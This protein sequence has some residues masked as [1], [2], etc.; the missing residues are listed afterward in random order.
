MTG[1]FSL[2]INPLGKTLAIVLTIIFPKD[3]RLLVPVGKTL[4]IALIA[5][6]CTNDGFT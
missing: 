2:L 1:K 3:T 6:V 4:L 5:G